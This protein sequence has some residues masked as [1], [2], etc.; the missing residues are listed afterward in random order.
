[1]RVNYPN[2]KDH[3]EVTRGHEFTGALHNV[4]SAMR[5]VEDDDARQ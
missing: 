1:M 4:W 3:M 5:Q 2:Y